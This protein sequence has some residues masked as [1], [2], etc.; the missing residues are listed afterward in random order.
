MPSTLPTG[1]ALLS[2]ERTEDR[3][4]LSRPA[5]DVVGRLRAVSSTPAGPARLLGHHA[6]DGP[7]GPPETDRRLP[8]APGG[9]LRRRRCVAADAAAGSPPVSRKERG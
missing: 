8:V 4:G 6:V 7:V 2:D 5:L 3:C 9:A 1:L